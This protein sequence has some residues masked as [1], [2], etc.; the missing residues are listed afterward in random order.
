MFQ[1]KVF[2]RDPNEACIISHHP[3]ENKSTQD[4]GKVT[5]RLGQAAT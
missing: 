1:K 4:S 5:D 3:F 2:L